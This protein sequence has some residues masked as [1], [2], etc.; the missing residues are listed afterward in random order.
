MNSSLQLLCATIMN[1]DSHRLCAPLKV[2]FANSVP[3]CFPTPYTKTINLDQL[4]LLLLF[5]RLMVVGNWLIYNVFDLLIGKI[6]QFWIVMEVDLKC[7]FR[8]C[9][10]HISVIDKQHITKMYLVYVYPTVLVALYIV[11]VLNKI[12]K[13]YFSHFFLTLF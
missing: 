13:Q 2:V 4:L 6:Q 12:L 3:H 8:T 11:C 1:P 10:I 7:T 9:Y 5:Q